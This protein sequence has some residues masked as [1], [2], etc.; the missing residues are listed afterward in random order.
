MTDLPLTSVI[1]GF[2]MNGLKFYISSI[3]K[4]V[5]IG[6]KI[7]MLNFFIPY[8]MM[9][10]ALVLVPSPRSTTNLVV[11]LTIMAKMAGGDD[12]FRQALSD[13]A[14]QA[15]SLLDRYNGKELDTIERRLKPT[16]SASGSTTANSTLARPGNSKTTTSTATELL[17]A[18]PTLNKLQRRRMTSKYA[19]K[20]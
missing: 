8:G 1:C 3:H 7:Y 20:K 9:Q 4:S 14:R 11:Q 19:P 12:D 15:R 16:E 2:Q 17:K 13:I 10:C 5:R 6:S 18:F